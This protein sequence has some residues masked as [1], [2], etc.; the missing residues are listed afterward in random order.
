[1]QSWRRRGVVVGRT[2][3]HRY[4][5]ALGP[6]LKKRHSTP[7][8]KSGRMSPR[9]GKPGARAKRSSKLRD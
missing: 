4:L 3:V 6:T 2:S 9:R 1:M 7:P 8:S 5:E